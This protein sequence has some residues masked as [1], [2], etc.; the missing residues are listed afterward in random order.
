MDD[1]RFDFF[2][3][4]FQSNSAM[5][6][7]VQIICIFSI[8]F[9]NNADGIFLSA[10]YFVRFYFTGH[11]HSCSVTFTYSTLERE[12]VFTFIVNTITLQPAV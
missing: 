7:S 1:F 9:D 3:F 5:I 4:N 2:K 10:I 12:P 11:S 8:M 6:I